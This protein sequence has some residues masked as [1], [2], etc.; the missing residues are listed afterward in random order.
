MST[1]RQLK[2][3]PEHQAAAGLWDPGNS[4]RPGLRSLVRPN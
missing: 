4:A 3:L 2:A 1:G